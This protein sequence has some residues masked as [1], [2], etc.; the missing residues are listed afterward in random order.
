MYCGLLSESLCLL[1][2][3]QRLFLLFRDY[4]PGLPSF[5]IGVRFRIQIFH[6]VAISNGDPANHQLNEIIF[7]WWRAR[8][9]PNRKL[10]Y[11]YIYIYMG[12]N[13]GYIMRMFESKFLLYHRF[14]CIWWIKYTVINSLKITKFFVV[15]KTFI[16]EPKGTLIKWK[17][18]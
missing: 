5:S 1:G 7:V 11:I 4:S 13:Q 2:E 9:I 14:L 16:F 18:S 6:K 3:R 15:R 8:V 17:K 12:L 10:I